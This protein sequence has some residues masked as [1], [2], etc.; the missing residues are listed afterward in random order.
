MNNAPL[1]PELTGVPF[2][3]R[4]AAPV[5]VKSSE[6][7]V[8]QTDVATQAEPTRQRLSFWET[9]YYWIMARG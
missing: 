7:Q 3:E 8:T 2:E 9:A 4:K 6:P 5:P 1:Q